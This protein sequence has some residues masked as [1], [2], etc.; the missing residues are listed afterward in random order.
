MYRVCLDDSGRVDLPRRVAAALSSNDLAIASSSSQHVLLAVDGAGEASMTASLGSMGVADVLSFFNMFRK[1]G[2]LYLDLS[3][4]NRQ[5]FFQ[6]GEII[7]AT[8]QRFEEDLGEIL[9]ELGK[10]ERNVLTAIRSDME[11]GATLSQVLVRKNIVAARDLWLATRHQVEAIVYNLFSSQDGGCYFVAQELERDDIVRL[12]MSTQNLIMEGLR[13]VDERALYLRRFRS[14]DALLSYTGKSPANLSDE[15]KRLVSFVYSVSATVAQLVARSGLSEF[16]ALRI[17]YQ[18]LEKGLVEVSQPEA[19]TVSSSFVELFEVYNGVLKLLHDCVSESTPSFLHDVNRFLREV[20]HPMLYVVRGIC[21]EKDGVV[22]GRKIMKNLVG[23]EPLEQ[24]KMIVEALSELVYM[25][26]TIAR[27][28]L[29]SQGS[30]ELIRRV[31]EITARAKR[32]VG[33]DTGV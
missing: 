11:E 1:T 33:E 8:S 15:E 30:A 9:C 28:A 14:M 19:V 25:E 16:D 29:G 5:V 10:L 6:D 12:S 31:Q 17:L 20:P 18:L 32:L 13:R 2:V 23:L 22:D 21:L 27:R 3:D 24:K 26:C 4:G 7:F